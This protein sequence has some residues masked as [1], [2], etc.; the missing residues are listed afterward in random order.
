MS[1]NVIRHIVFTLLAITWTFS[2]AASIKISG[3]VRDS[4]TN[5]V[6]P[7]A[8]VSAIGQ[9]WAVQANDKGNF[10]MELSSAP[11][12]LHVSAL[13]FSPVTISYKDFLKQRRQIFVASTG[14]RLTEVVVK[15]KKEKYSKKNNPAV[16]FVN[17][18]RNSR[19]LTDPRRNDNYNYSQYERITLALNN[20]SPDSKNNLIL[21]KFDFLRDH[22]DTSEVSGSPILTLSTREKLSEVHY[23]KNPKSE[24]AEVQALRQEGLDDFLD[25][26]NMQTL[27]EDFFKNIDLY[28]NDIDLLHNRMVSPLSKIAPD[29]YKFYLTDTVMIDSVRCIELSFVPRNSESFGFTGR[30]YVPEGDSTMFIKKVIMN[31][32]KDINLNFIEGLYINQEYKKAA[33]GSRLPVR[34]DLVAEVAIIPGTQGLYFRRSTAYANHN[35]NP[36]SN[37]AVFEELGKEVYTGNVYARDTLYWESNRLIPLTSGE[38][39]I[40]A[41]TTGLRSNKFY[42]LAEGFVKRMVL[43]YIP[44]GRPSKFDLGPINTVVSHNTLEGFRF[45]AGGI[46][47]ANLSKRLFA[48][49]YVAYGTRDH[50]MKYSGELEYSFLDKRYHSREFPVHSL[51]LIHA[52][53]VNM[54]GQHYMFTNAD[55]MFLSFKRHD[56]NQIDYLRTTSLDYT[57]ELRNNFSIVASVKHQRQEATHYMTFIT[58][59]GTRYG[60]YNESMFSL[61]L[62]YAPGEKVYQMASDRIRINEET[63]TFMLTHTYAPKGFAG[64]MFEIN[65]TEFSVSNRFWFSAFGYLDA[66]VK[67]GHLWNSVPYPD[68]LIPNANLSYTIQP[69]SFALMNPMEFMNDSYASWDLTYWANGAIFNYI[70]Y[71]KRLKLREVFSFRGIWGHLSKRNN[72]AYNPSLFAFPEISNTQPMSAMPYMEIGVG[73]DNIFRILRLDYVW[74]LSYRNV[75]GADKGGLRLELHFTF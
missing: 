45:R 26:A 19:D 48:R 37:P 74:R 8:T 1:N 9:Q 24:K 44:T 21:N 34:D 62:R 66:I 73:I 55:N 3:S 65:K 49:G 30:V 61:Q 63:P 71:F 32:P 28:E 27:Y 54:L 68:L 47:T 33:D 2:A 52:Y 40:P 56:D 43:G 16:D 59:A 58:P 15:P 36:S 17:K 64:N 20:I 22:I 70:P 35:F 41:I 12:S 31:V 18:I 13:G 57:L 75:P 42:R 60:H 53:D 50:K 6:V 11:D 72:P 5:Q 23:R 29:F 10:K 67:A 14:V 51:R 7:Y 25:Q 38:V 46:T 39:A 69:E 4:V